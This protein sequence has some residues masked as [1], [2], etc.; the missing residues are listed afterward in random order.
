MTLSKRAQLMLFVLLAGGLFFAMQ[1]FMF[2]DKVEK[3]GE[4]FM[5]TDPYTR[6][7]RVRQWTEGGGWFDSTM[8]RSNAPYGETLHWTRPMDVLI[9]GGAKAAGLFAGQ[10]DA[11]EKAG[12]FISPALGI[13]SFGA[14]LWGASL[15]MEV[16]RLPLVLI[17]YFSQFF[18]LQYFKIGRPDH[19]SLILLLFLLFLGAAWR[20]LEASDSGRWGFWAAL[21]AGL[22]FWVS[23]ESLLMPVLLA[24][25]LTLEWIAG[26]DDAMKRLGAFAFPLLFLTGLFLLVERPL[27][28]LGVVSYDKISAPYLAPLALLALFAF[29]GDCL[30]S[31]RAGARIAYLLSF[32]AA[33]LWGLH[34][35]FPLMLKGPF[36][37]VNPAIVG[38]WLS[39]VS[40]VQSIPSLGWDSA[41]YIMGLPFAGLAALVWAFFKRRLTHLSAWE[42]ILAGLI[43]YIPLGLY[44]VRWSAY[45]QILSVLP[46]TL[47]LFGA[48]RR[49]ERLGTA[50]W[51]PLLRT[52]TVL[53][54][55]LGFFFAVIFFPGGESGGKESA[56]EKGA[57]LR[58]VCQW[59]NQ[60]D[61]E[62]GAI[63]L[64][65]VDDGPQIL[66][67]TELRVIATPYHRND[68]GILYYFDL[69]KE[70]D[71]ETI[72][73]KLRERSVSLIL[74]RVPVE[75]EQASEAP[76]NDGTE[77]P[78]PAEAEPE[79]ESP[80][81]FKS[82]LKSGAVPAWL[83]P[84]T[85]PED[86]AG[87]R[88]YETAL[89]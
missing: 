20:L 52:V 13:L 37:Q 25:V 6:M 19:H 1:L 69:M 58:A 84:V 32:G 43:V 83:V 9:A 31:D 18:T 12:L 42:L 56:S 3:T 4:D 10:A 44:Q 87:Y 27:G 36:S 81:D 54:V 51:R 30:R 2:V 72:Q 35:L 63:L 14:L 11:L 33:G 67:R 71:M 70:T 23:V 62:E 46:V 15:L 82:R 61:Y 78:E 88:L 21:F 40:E 66:Y 45:A 59:L 53:V 64:A 60:Q 80:P 8:P 26:R 22:A 49:V 34:S 74:Q 77:A 16:D 17:V 86:L 85:L 55:C 75:K 48:I 73:D 28:G 29:L 5:G 79:Q 24:L 38:P 68:A 76:E 39:R 7:V 50:K 41:L 47:L 89:D 57:S 65:H